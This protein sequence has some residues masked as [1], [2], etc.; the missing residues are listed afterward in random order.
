MGPSSGLD[1]TINKLRDIRADPDVAPEMC[2][3]PDF[4]CSQTKINYS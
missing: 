2:Y 1:L 3:G 4:R